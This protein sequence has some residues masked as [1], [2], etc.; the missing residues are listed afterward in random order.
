MAT[1]KNLLLATEENNYQPGLLKPKVCGILVV[2]FMVLGLANNLFFNQRRVSALDLTPQNIMNSVNNERSIRNVTTLNPDSRLTKAAEYKAQDMINR[3]YFSHTDPEGNYIWG[4]IVSNGYN[5]Y[6]QLGENLAIEFDSTESL[7]AAWMN[8]P[9][10]RANLLNE[11]FRDQGMGVSFGNT[12]NGE[13]NSSI[14]NT[15]GTLVAKKETPA[16]APIPTPLP[17]TPPVSIP[18]TTTPPK[19]IIKKPPVIPTPAPT[20]TPSP[21]TST[22]PEASS[23]LPTTEPPKQSQKI[24]IHK[25]SLQVAASIKGAFLVVDM[26]IAIEGKPDTVALSVGQY[27]TLLSLS[28]P[29]EKKAT[30]TETF[31]GQMQLPLHTAGQNDPVQIFAQDRYGQSDT[32]NTSLQEIAALPKA[33]NTTAVIQTPAQQSFNFYKFNRYAAL[34]LGII[35]ALFM[36]FDV[37]RMLEHKLEHLDKKINNLVLMVLSLIVI[38]VLYWV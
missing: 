36:A 25:D 19:T 29:I 26:A 32:L 23:T 37:K 28:I 18:K 24:S 35:L 1:I 22:P 20:P 15:F 16:P 17:V 8:S 3:H 7:V 10:H 30:T 11:N 4:T 2:L 14:A 21:S 12:S 5:P 31:N 27:T 33:N 13:Y 34:A 9:T 6:L 38:A